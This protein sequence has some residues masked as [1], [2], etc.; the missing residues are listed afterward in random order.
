MIEALSHVLQR[1]REPRREPKLCGQGISLLLGSKSRYL[2]TGLVV[3]MILS[4]SN[5]NECSAT[6][7][8]LGLD[9]AQVYKT[10]LR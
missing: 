6:G 7:N 9:S 8:P 5:A 3:G 4:L 1:G 10:S 2:H